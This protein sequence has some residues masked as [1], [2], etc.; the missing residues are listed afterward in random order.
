[1]FKSLRKGASF[2]TIEGIAKKV[3]LLL[4]EGFEDPK[5]ARAS[6]HFISTSSGIEVFIEGMVVLNTEVH[7]M[8]PCQR[9]VRALMDFIVIVRDH[10][11]LSTSLRVEV[12]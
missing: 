6:S 4:R 7:F 10:L 12:L 8:L 11:A 5:S 3:E 1:M 9:V 2:Q